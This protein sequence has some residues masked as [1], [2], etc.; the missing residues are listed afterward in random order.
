MGGLAAR[1]SGQQAPQERSAPAADAEQAVAQMQARIA[2]LEARL[3]RIEGAVTVNEMEEVIINSNTNLF[4]RAQ[5][6]LEIQASTV[7]VAAATVTLN[8]GFT[9]ASGVVQCDTII[10]NSV[11]GASYTPGAGNIW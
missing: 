11:I 5:A 3:V 7:T 2:D 10:A 1:Q 9:R 6:T 4:L 8:T